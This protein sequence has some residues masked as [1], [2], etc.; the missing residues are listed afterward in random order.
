METVKVTINDIEVEVNANSTILEAAKMVDIQIPTLCYLNLEGFDIANQTASCRVCVVEVEG[1]PALV[2]SCAEIVTDGMVV[3]TDSPKAIAARRTNVELLLSNHPKEC[4]TCSKNLE[5]ELQELAQRLGVM[6][7]SYEGERMLHEIDHSSL[8]LV[9]DP[10]KCIMCRRCETMCNEVQTC[11]ILSAVSRGFAAHVGPAFHLNMVDTSCT[12]CGQ[13][14]AVCP[15]GALTEVNNVRSVVA[16]LNDPTKHVVAQVAPAI[17]VAIGEMFD[18]DPGTISTGQLATSL[19]R[20]GF[21]GVFDTDF[22]ADLTILEEASELV[23]RLENNGRLPIL[24]SCCPA[25]VR[26]IEHQFPDLLDIPSTCKSPQ[27][28]FGAIA[29][30]YYAKKVGLDPKDIVV[31]SIMPCLA[32]KTEAAREEMDIDHMHNVDL[33]LT[34]REFGAM[35]KEAGTNFAHL[36]V[37]E[38]DSILG[39]STGAAVIFGTTGGVIEAAV[40]TAYEWITGDELEN[41]EFKQ[42]RGLEGIR[43][44]TVEIGDKSLNIGIAHGLGN[45]RK[46]LE[47]IREGKSNYHAIEI[48]ACPG[49]CIGGGGQPYHHGDMEILRKRQEAIY[50]E[51]AGMKVR[52]S[53][54]NQEVLKLYEE[55]LGEPYGDRAHKLLHTHY[56]PKERI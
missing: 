36:P 30:T 23:H 14:V 44:A 37:G 41:V 31:V 10:E 24:T 34:T 51:D 39:E 33:V 43:S 29:K 47:E 13:C 5:C 55:F 12:F 19:R 54:K 25:W 50:R 40:R 16:A 3:R 46:L 8:S 32:K 38:F 18:M 15:T 42:L 7:I 52:K 45:A 56:S 26:F 48:M 20:L 49:G 35:L 21:D 11:G 53:H 6:E 22:A 9:K 1:R 2:P 4:L 17:R 27:M 28:M